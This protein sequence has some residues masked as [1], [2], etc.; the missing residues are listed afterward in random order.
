MLKKLLI[1][2]VCASFLLSTNVK[3]QT[4]LYLPPEISNNPRK[5]PVEVL[6]VMPCHL[7]PG[8]VESNSES[9]PKEFPKS[10]T[11]GLPDFRSLNLFQEVEYFKNSNISKMYFY[12]LLDARYANPAVKTFVGFRAEKVIEKREVPKEGYSPDGEYYADWPWASMLPEKSNSPFKTYVPFDKRGKPASM[13][14]HY[15]VLEWVYEM[16]VPIVS[17]TQDKVFGQGRCTPYHIYENIRITDFTREDLERWETFHFAA[18]LA[19]S[20][21]PGGDPAVKFHE[22]YGTADPGCWAEFGI[23]SASE[24]GLTLLGVKFL[25]SAGD[26]ITAGSRILKN[27]DRVKDATAKS[28]IAFSV[29]YRGT[30]VLQHLFNRDFFK[31]GI[32][33]ADA[34][35]LTTGTTL[36]LKAIPDGT[37]RR[38][39]NEV[40][41]D[42]EDSLD[43]HQIV[44][45]LEDA[46]NP[47][48]EFI[49]ELDP[50]GLR[51]TR[52]AESKW[53]VVA[54]QDIADRFVKKSGFKPGSGYKRNPDGS[55]QLDESG[56]PIIDSDAGINKFI[57]LLKDSMKQVDSGETVDGIPLEVAQFLKNVDEYNPRL[58]EYVD[59]N[60]FTKTK[61]TTSGLFPRLRS[62]GF[63]HQKGQHIIASQ[64]DDGVIIDVGGETTGPLIMATKGLDGTTIPE[65]ARVEFR[66]HTP[67]ERD[68]AGSLPTFR[69]QRLSAR[70]KSSWIVQMNGHYNHYENL[71]R[72]L[73][74]EEVA[75][76]ESL[77][78]KAVWEHLI[79]HQDGL[80]WAPGYLCVI[81]EGKRDAA[82][83]EYFRE[84]LRG[85]VDNLV[86]EG[87][88]KDPIFIDDAT[89]EGVAKWLAGITHIE[90]IPGDLHIDDL[91]SGVKHD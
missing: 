54:V 43:N 89:A 6:P 69:V 64:S 72:S 88:I 75:T 58:L 56:L 41:S 28:L 82:K 37:L 7:L 78:H 12:E 3:A 57:D 16:C 74:P 1:I 73:S 67:T 18:L 39:G 40:A 62:D 87:K 22:C 83:V 90:W 80:H 29:S 24:V 48:R 10:D 50:A 20:F 53:P 52:V 44:D 61:L 76:L 25:N 8:L 11:K 21:L 38:A 84:L 71:C 9:F 14:N 4:T 42:L 81:A 49:P 13:R 2:T 15:Q 55:F 86:K 45:T 34:V 46:F 63:R 77:A 17:C 5:N 59:P 68:P 27:A 35:F 70:K 51:N 66:Y 23:V 47:R 26:A 19:A 30:E 36:I 31:A 65:V 32:A 85:R 33:V 60:D 79:V 91:I